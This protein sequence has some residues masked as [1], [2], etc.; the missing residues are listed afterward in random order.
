VSEEEF[1]SALREDRLPLLVV[2][3]L[4]TWSD[5]SRTGK[6]VSDS[7]RMPLDDAARLWR[8][9]GF[10]EAGDAPVFNDDDIEALRTIRGF[11]ELGISSP[12]TSVQVTRVLGQSM[13]RL[14]D[15]FVGSTDAALQQIGYPDWATR[16]EDEGLV[17]A[18]ALAFS[19][20]VVLP[21]MERLLIYAWHRH[22]QAAARRRVS[23]QRD[24]S[25]EGAMVARLTVGF[26]D[27]VGF[28]ALSS[29]LTA[30]A[31]ARV[32]DRFEDLAHSTVVS[33]GG[34]PVKMIGDEVMFVTGDPISA[35]RIGL[36]LVEAYADD[37]L[38]SDV[39]VGVATGPVLSRE[40]DFFGSVVNRAHRTVSI[41]DPGT[42]L[43]GDEVHAEIVAS[44]DGEPSGLDWRALR[45]RELKDIGRVRLWNVG[46]RGRGASERRRSGHRWRRLAE[47]NTEL[48][49]LREKGEQVLGTIAAVRAGEAPAGEGEG[50]A[51]RIRPQ[52]SGS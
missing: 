48:A 39:R 21:N 50:Q 40:G 36:A 29:Q 31:L 3:R 34:R 16:P 37:E 28:T 38:L 47:M 42:V 27:M 25:H 9:L 41:A 35:V 45:P 19:S 33:G 15:A 8:A 26:A 17:L 23:V 4:L 10:P 7:S 1:E 32:V 22:I 14:A 46:R 12:E 30:E 13:S 49:H 5:G 18:E 11:A 43:V 6:E 52:G 44:R 51:A 24:G 2:D 20:E